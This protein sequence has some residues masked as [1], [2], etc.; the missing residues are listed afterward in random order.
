MA[1]R[2]A[3]A[4]RDQ[5]RRRGGQ[6]AKVEGGGQEGARRVVQESSRAACYQAREQQ[7]TLPI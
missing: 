2:A 4:Y 3:F 1:R 6:K 7:V 5:G